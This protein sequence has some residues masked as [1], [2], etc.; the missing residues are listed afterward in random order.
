MAGDSGTSR[1]ATDVRTLGGRSMM[2][3]RAE[4][5]FVCSLGGADFGLNGPSVGVASADMLYH[6]SD[7]PPESCARE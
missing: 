7:L 5:G 4:S 6:A 1:A 2:D 3:M